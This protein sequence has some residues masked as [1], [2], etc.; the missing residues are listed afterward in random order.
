MFALFLEVYFLCTRHKSVVDTCNNLTRESVEWHQSTILSADWNLCMAQQFSTCSKDS[1]TI[2]FLFVLYFATLFSF[3]LDFPYVE[4]IFIVSECCFFF[5]NK[6]VFLCWSVKTLF[7]YQ[8]NTN[9][10]ILFTQHFMIYSICDMDPAQHSIKCA[11]LLLRIHSSL[12][13]LFMTHSYYDF[14][15]NKQTIN[16]TALYMLR[17]Q[18]FF[19]P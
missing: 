18:I 9:V 6:L 19:H 3:G 5:L 16:I 7:L 10:D 12:H 13:F 2:I 8:L 14:N 17:I 11:I 15:K 4:H 1:N